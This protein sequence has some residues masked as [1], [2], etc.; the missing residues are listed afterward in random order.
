MSPEQFLQ[1]LQ[2]NA[3]KLADKVEGEFQELTNPP[4]PAKYE[5]VAGEVGTCLSLLRQ[6]DERLNALQET[7]EET[8]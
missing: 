8:T 2:S 5:A 7:S 6:V 1:V 3:R 4:P